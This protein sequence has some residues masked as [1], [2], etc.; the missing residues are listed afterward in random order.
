MRQRYKT[1]L[2]VALAVLALAG[3]A[4]VTAPHA[5]AGG[6]TGSI[7]GKVLDSSGSAVPGAKIVVKNLDDGSVRELSTNNSGDYEITN[8]PFGRYS[9]A[10]ELD[11]GHVVALKEVD[12]ANG[13]EATASAAASG[14]QIQATIVIESTQTPL[15]EK[16]RSQL[17]KTM[18]TFGMLEL[19]G[20]HTLNGIALLHTGVFPNP[21]SSIGTGLSEPVGDIGSR[22]SVNGTRPNFNYFN[23]DGGY[24]MDPLTARPRQSLPPEA[25]QTF[26]MVTSNFPAELGRYAGSYVNQVARSGSNGLHGTLM[27][28]WNGSTFNSFSS[29]ER[30]TFDALRA[31]GLSDEQ[32]TRLARPVISDQKALV[33][34]GFPFWKD[35]VFSFSSWDRDWFKSSGQPSGAI[36]L[37]PASLLELET[38]DCDFIPSS[39]GLLRNAFPLAN[40]NVNRGAISFVHMGVPYNARLGEFNRGLVATNQPYYRDYWRFLQKLD[41]KISDKNSLNVRYLVD[42]MNN[43]G[44]PT[45]IPGQEISE[46]F[47][48][49]SG[50]INDIHIFSPKAVNE[51]R[52]T[53][54]RL[55]DTFASNQ[56]MGLNIIGFNSIGNPNFP[57]SRKETSYQFADNFTWSLT[58]HTLRFGIEAVRYDISDVFGFNSLGTLTYPS[59]LDFLQDT[60]SVFTQ[61]SGSPVLRDRGT[62]VYGAFVQDDWKM[63][64]S[65]A[66]NIGLRYDYSQIPSGLFTGIL[67]PQRNFGPRFG[68]A[69]APD[70]GGFLFEKT[71]IRGG[72]SLLYNQEVVF[73]LLPLVARNFPNGVYT[74][75]NP[76]S[77]LSIL[78]NPPAGQT[79][80]QFIA[81]GG[82]PDLLPRTIV[83]TDSERRFKTP[84]IQNYDLG[85]ERELPGSFVFRAY[86]IGSKGTHLLSQIE[87]NPGITT[88]AFNANPG[89]FSGLN[90]QPV[91]D[92]RGATI[93]F[94][95]NTALGST[96]SIEPGANSI[97]NSGQL[98]LEKRFSHGIQLGVNYTYSSFITDSDNF[99][100]PS[101]NPFNLSADRARSDFDQPHRFVANYAFQVPHISGRPVMTALLSGWQISGI[102][103]VASGNPYSVLNSNNALG[104]LPG[105]N[106]NILTQ[107]A[108]IN[109]SGVPGTATSVDVANPQFVANPTNSGIFS[110]QGRNTLRTGRTINTDLALVK[111]TRTFSENQSLQLRLEV[112]NVFNHHSL[113][114][115]PPN[116]VGSSINTFQ[117]LNQGNF[118]VPGRSLMLTARYFF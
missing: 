98:T 91:T 105:Q 67:P 2:A 71:A 81:A 79:P 57:Q 5:W 56:G 36:G 7:T 80:E 73:Q 115:I 4:A 26:N 34:A 30:R 87:T 89:F 100:V 25:M 83:G 84:Y 43:P 14:A 16:A 92:S 93:G 15:V 78:A 64:R 19:P 8:L 42:D 68:F 49:H 101:S 96:L 31:Q 65:L 108:S 114:Q 11:N 77:G 117:F 29:R 111:S 95:P 1:R 102:T 28:T 104:L 23:I 38:A 94:R 12:V 85:I 69:W 6:P 61:F 99:L 13:A 17:N 40:T 75:A 70:A 47:R 72:Y 32:A 86:Y 44:Q 112:F 106:P 63:S 10:A 22:I 52:F 74:A 21:F 116:V 51:F 24:N 50:Q 9:I 88:A 110:N 59:L 118:D 90:L 46:Q 62:M 76:V 82:N 107:R 55:R 20:R 58:G 3:G 39:F 27:Y 97:Y 33:S 35:R 60:N 109:P 41:F 53:I 66:I 113:N 54:G 103:T 37:T 45:P 48:N 18:N